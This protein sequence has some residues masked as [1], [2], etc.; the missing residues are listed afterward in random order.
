MCQQ[1]VSTVSRRG[2]LLGGLVTGLTLAGC[3]PSDTTAP[4]A[5]GTSTAPRSTS[6]EA[7]RTPSPTTEPTDDAPTESPTRPGIDPDEVAARFAD[8]RPTEW[9]LAVTGV[10]THLPADATF[11][12]ALTLDACGGPGGYG[13]D[14][15]LL[16]LL[17]RHEI[18]AT[19]F[20]NQRWIEANPD[21]AA[22]LAANPLYLLGN[23]GSAH[24]P[25][26]V[27]GREAYGITGTADARA[28]V[29]EVWS[30]HQVLTE[31]T[32]TPPT[33]FRSGTAHY[34]E[35]AVEIVEALGERV[36]G[37]SVNGDAGATHPA[38]TVA[39]EVGSAVPTDIV[40]A[41]LNQPAAGTADGFAQAL[42]RLLDAGA[43][44][45]QLP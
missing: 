8:R 29:E 5:T 25:L 15:K 18:A 6:P 23:H 10:V 24:R 11:D 43:R 45:V 3:A 42:P 41:H 35:V 13:V 2:L 1:C 16:D 34:D 30:N 21:R 36:A 37:F 12:V 22:E 9:G 31:L 7:G 19:L 4:R 14:E 33:W 27:S 38:A 20:L 44:F 26:S 40:I 17:E 28:A 39:A 32:G